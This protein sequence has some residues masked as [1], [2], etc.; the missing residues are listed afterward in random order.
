MPLQQP[1]LTRAPAL[2]AQGRAAERLGPRLL[3]AAL[4]FVWLAAFAWIRPLYLPDEGRYSMVAWEMFGSGRWAVPTLDGLPFFHK[5]PLFYWIATAAMHLLGPTPMA[6]RVPS[7]L[8][9]TAAATALLLFLRRW[10]APRTAHW[11]LAVLATQPFFFV[12]AQFANLDMLVA[13]CIACTVLLAAHA[14]LLDMAGQPSQ[15]FVAA[16]WLCAALGVLAKGLIG[17]VLPALV[18]VAWLTAMRRP[19]AALRLLSAP[20]LA[21]FAAVVM[22]W[23]VEMQLRYPGFL[24]Y[25]FVYHHLQRFAQGGFNNVEPM[26]YYPVAVAL[27][28]LPS[29]IA[30]PWAMKRW[31]AHASAQQ[32]PTAP[33]A[34]LMWCWLAV[35]VLFFSIPQSKPVGYAM[36]ALA[37]LAWIVTDAALAQ[38]WGER[39]LALCAGAAAAVV[40]ASTLGVAVVHRH[41]HEIVGSALRTQRH[42]G[43]PVVYLDMNPYDVAFYARLDTPPLVVSDWTDPRIRLRDDWHKELF[44]AAQFA[45]HDGAARLIG[46]AQLPAIVCAHD[47]SWIVGPPGAPPAVP[48]RVQQAAGTVEAVAW[49]VQR[50]LAMCSRGTGPR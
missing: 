29:S 14:V 46:P 31:T 24:H 42:A 11:T 17:A 2:A 27:L 26:W 15:R 13:G 36:P 37:P 19:R 49:R 8:G 5:P 43:E 4:V 47:T 30:L 20:G 21:L 41:S 22:P 6:M 34:R 48:G 9:A 45:P 40:V 33:V 28:A 25:F 38:R 12:G 35:I 23:F 32:T 7:L 50:N 44:D 3:P 18:I 16:A 10:D 1:S 39:F